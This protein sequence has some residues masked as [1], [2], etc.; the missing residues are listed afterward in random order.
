MFMNGSTSFRGFSLATA[1]LVAA[2][3]T[4]LAAAT[5]QGN[6]VRNGDFSANASVY[7]SFPGNSLPPNPATAT[8]WKI[9]Y[10]ANGK[11]GGQ[12]GINGP[13]T[14]FYS[15]PG[16]RNSPEPFAPTSTAGVRDFLFMQ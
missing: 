5:A 3:L 8:D 13:D 16:P 4:M 1:A 12:A 7:T 2:G 14:G 15:N 9:S 10:T 6:M 11:A